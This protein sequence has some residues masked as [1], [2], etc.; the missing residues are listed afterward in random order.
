VEEFMI[1]GGVP[2]KPIKERPKNQAYKL[3]RAAWFR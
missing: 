1:V 2:A 3:G